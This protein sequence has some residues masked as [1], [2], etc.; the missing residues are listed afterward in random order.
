MPTSSLPWSYGGLMRRVGY[1]PSTSPGCAHGLLR[2]SGPAYHARPHDGGCDDVFLDHSRI[3]RSPADPPGFRLLVA[4]SEHEGVWESG[5]WSAYY[6]DIWGLHHRA[7][8]MK[9]GS[10]FPGITGMVFAADSD[11]LLVARQQMALHCYRLM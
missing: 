1:R 7:F 2:A 3:Y 6:A 10:A 8:R 4:F 11:P 9:A 5:D